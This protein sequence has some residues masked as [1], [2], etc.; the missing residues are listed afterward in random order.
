[1]RHGRLRQLYAPLDIGG[2]KTGFLVDRASTFFFERAQNAAAS[3]VGNGVQEAV[4]I[5]SGVS[6]DLFF[7]NRVVAVADEAGSQGLGL[8]QVGVGSD[9]NVIELVSGRIV[10][11]ERWI[12][13]LL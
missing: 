13:L 10:S 2:T 7:H 9:L 3:G 4:Q 11:C 1:M 5:G 12:L 8:F 6:H